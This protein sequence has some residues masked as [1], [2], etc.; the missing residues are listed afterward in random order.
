MLCMCASVLVGSK[1]WVQC[2]MSNVPIVCG[3]D[4]VSLYR[5]WSLKLESLD[6]PPGYLLEVSIIF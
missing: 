6:L 2:V 1:V 4:L 3:Q 5:K